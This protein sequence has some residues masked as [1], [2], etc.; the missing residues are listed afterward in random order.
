M[1]FLISCS[2][3][4]PSVSLCTDNIQ[5][6]S[7][8]TSI[9]RHTDKLQEMRSSSSS[10]FSLCQLSLAEEDGDKC[11]LSS[12][13]YLLG[14]SL[15]DGLEGAWEGEEKVGLQYLFIDMVRG[16]SNAI[17]SESAGL[18]M[19]ITAGWLSI[20]WLLSYGKPCP[21][22]LHLNHLKERFEFL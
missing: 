18:W 20:A 6:K 8:A 17:E 10:S 2:V 12:I 5:M 3:T 1:S 16:K 15:I 19:E 11:A 7:N 9:D 22:H 21:C 14:M 13:N 4:R